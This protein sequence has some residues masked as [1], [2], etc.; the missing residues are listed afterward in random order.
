MESSKKTIPILAA[1]GL[2]FLALP[3]FAQQLV[4]DLDPAAGTGSSSPAG[5]L[6]LIGQCD[7]TEAAIN[8]T[9][10]TG[11]V[12]ILGCCRAEAAGK[13]IFGGGNTTALGD[14]R[15]YFF[16]DDPWGRP[17]PASF[18][19]IP[20]QGVF[21]VAPG[22]GARDWGWDPVAGRAY[23]GDEANQVWEV[24]PFT[25]VYTTP[26]GTPWTTLTGSSAGTLRAIATY[27]N[28]ATPN[29]LLLA[30]ANFSS[31]LELWQIDRSAGNAATLL[32][33][34]GNPGA[35]YGASF[36]KNGT[37]LLI[38]GQAQMTSCPAPGLH[39]ITAIDVA[40][41]VTVWTRGGDSTIPGAA[42]NTAG[43]IAGGCEVATVSGQ[44]VIAVLHQATNDSVG[45]V[46]Y[47][48]FAMLGAPDCG[49][50]RLVPVGD[51]ELGN[52]SYG[53]RLTAGPAGGLTFVILGVPPALNF[54]FAGCIID[55]NFVSPGIF[56]P[57]PLDPAGSSPVLGLPIPL[58]PSIDGAIVIFDTANVSGT[59]TISSSETMTVTV[60]VS[61]I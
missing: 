2:V 50:S 9:G 15:I 39:R 11:D 10:P 46:P 38:F 41:G 36:A 37:V 40:S 13:W 16:D 33:T 7:V 26:P 6:D 21:P 30:T 5:G 17:N 23:H 43:G 45:F 54:P 24:D 14:E 31:P 58:N 42:P 18:N 28:P 32:T 29:L 4:D 61:M 53:L 55:A 35:T 44:T 57:A 1:I 59:G 56:F 20:A 3:A 8:L 34:F 19:F 47:T 27:T 49:G 52:T 60:S 25:E 12:R 22:W 48:G 51:S